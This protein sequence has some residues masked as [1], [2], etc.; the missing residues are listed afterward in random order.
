[1]SHMTIAKWKR[2]GPTK[3]ETG[4]YTVRGSYLLGERQLAAGACGP[5]ADE[6]TA[7]FD[8]LIASFTGHLNEAIEAAVDGVVEKFVL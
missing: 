8:R 5:T 4:G 6:A 2:E 3:L 7:Q 1:M